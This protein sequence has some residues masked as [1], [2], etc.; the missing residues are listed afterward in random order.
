MRYFSNITSVVVDKF[1]PFQS[2]G[3]PGFES[4][5]SQNVTSL[6]LTLFPVSLLPNQ[7]KKGKKEVSLYFLTIITDRI[8]YIFLNKTVNQSESPIKCS[9]EGNSNKVGFGD[10]NLQRPGQVHTVSSLRV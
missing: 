1:R 10:Y 6:T 4:Q 9:R 7:S 8:I 3:R 5:I 2:C